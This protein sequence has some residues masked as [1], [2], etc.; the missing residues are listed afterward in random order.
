MTS[1]EAG[2]GAILDR[3]RGS[4]RSTSHTVPAF[5]ASLSF[6]W[7]AV[8]L[9]ISA[10]CCLRTAVPHAAT[11]PQKHVDGEKPKKKKKKKAKAA[12]EE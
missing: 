2:P 6:S 4:L 11:V 9:G 1:R 8:P 7:A 3:S 5:P 10:P 12:D